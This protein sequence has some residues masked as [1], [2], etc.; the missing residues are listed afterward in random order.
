MRHIALL[1]FLR[2]RYGYFHS[3]AKDISRLALKR[4]AISTVCPHVDELHAEPLALDAGGSSLPNWQRTALEVDLRISA[5]EARR[6][7]LFRT[8]ILSIPDSTGLRDS[9][10]HR[11]LMEWAEQSHSVRLKLDQAAM[12][13]A[14][15]DAAA[16]ATAADQRLDGEEPPVVF[17][18]ISLLLGRPDEAG[19]VSATAL[20]REVAVRVIAGRLAIG[21]VSPELTRATL[22]RIEPFFVELPHGL[23]VAVGVV[24]TTGRMVPKDRVGVSAWGDPIDIRPGTRLARG[25]GGIVP[26][27]VGG[28]CQQRDEFGLAGCYSDA[29]AALQAGTNCPTANLDGAA[30]AWRARAAAK[31]VV[32]A[33]SGGGA[34]VVE[35][36][37][38][39]GRDVWACV[40]GTR[41]DGGGKVADGTVGTLCTTRLADGS[42]VEI[43]RSWSI[44]ELNAAIAVD[45]LVDGILAGSVGES[46]VVAE[47]R[48]HAVLEAAG[49]HPV[50]TAPCRFDVT[51][52]SGVIVEIGREGVSREFHENPNFV[53]AVEGQ[54]IATLEALVA[55]LW[56]ALPSVRPSSDASLPIGE[57]TRRLKRIG[58]ASAPESGA[59]V[60]FAPTG[61]CYEGWLD[62]ARV[63]PMPYQVADLVE[64]A[65]LGKVLA[66]ISGATLDR[67]LCEGLRGPS[68]VVTRMTGRGDRLLVTSR[69]SGEIVGV[70]R[71]G[72]VEEQIGGAQ[73][74]ALRTAVKAVVA[75]C[76]REIAKRLKAVDPWA[77]Y[78]NWAADHPGDHALLGA[79][80]EARGMVIDGACGFDPIDPPFG[81][82]VPIRPP[83]LGWAAEI[84]SLGRIA[85]NGD[86][87]GW[88]ADNGT[89]RYLVSSPER[90]LLVLESEQTPDS[91]VAA[92]R[93][94][95]RLDF[96]ISAIPA[97]RLRSRLER[98]G[99]MS[100][101]MAWRR[102]ACGNDVTIEPLRAAVDAA[103]AG[104]RWSEIQAVAPSSKWRSIAEVT[105]A[106]LGP[107]VERIDDLNARAAAISW[108]AAR[109]GDGNL[110]SAGRKYFISALQ[111]TPAAQALAAEEAFT[112]ILVA[113]TNRRPQS[114]RGW[115]RA[116]I[117]YSRQISAFSRDATP[118]EA[119]R[120][121]VWHKACRD[122]GAVVND[123]ETTR[124]LVA[125]A[126]R[127]VLFP[128][129]RSAYLGPNGP[130]LERAPVMPSPREPTRAKAPATA[131][132]WL[133][134]AGQLRVSAPGEK[135]TDAME[136]ESATLGAEKMSR[137]L[138]AATMA[139]TKRALLSASN[140]DRPLLEAG[141]VVLEEVERRSEQPRP[142]LV[143]A[144]VRRP[145]IVKTPARKPKDFER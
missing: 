18:P 102:G 145:E 96:L 67:A 56:P 118:D 20:K 137:D 9:D 125:Q 35:P 52:P 19:L 48:L 74:A 7:R 116:S 119:M 73:T 58:V 62:P 71:G 65:A 63:R 136:P 85:L 104:Q 144:P 13:P 111:K 22:D 6:L 108:M 142:A 92:A 109:D 90:A 126:T 133:R 106:R 4:G 78:M 105:A 24:D 101:D 50:R 107:L 130:E 25:L 47:D 132:E 21:A 66:D 14:L 42:T 41:R 60:L 15:W 30:A 103:A 114:E 139:A 54:E 2:K 68:Y 55:Q 121:A 81:T 128:D 40:G 122:E 26:E 91:A 51:L 131:Q 134:H 123:V 87:P 46:V 34:V 115:H 97:E 93:F 127:P 79:M 120:A 69:E 88:V 89:D 29:R 17:T 75:S 28:A 70:V 57:L 77:E 45:A 16:A 135:R 140:V 11:R 113:K 80:P 83:P 129:G 12:P 124:E 37:H 100:G 1:L 143:D 3:I 141:L 64:A 117:N 110:E 36:G 23:H 43:Y 49:Y 31:A 112:R 138:R 32:A 76:E 95:S 39:A 61:N 53:R 59:L 86:G 8:L 33:L 98:S 84:G 27:L 72:S 94:S 5:A 99:L 10:L 82:T 38:G 44:D